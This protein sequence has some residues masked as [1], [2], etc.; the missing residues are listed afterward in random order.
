[1]IRAGALVVWWSFVCDEKKKVSKRKKV[2]ICEERGKVEEA[3]MAKSNIA[4]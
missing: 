4:T 3:K 2:T 1:V